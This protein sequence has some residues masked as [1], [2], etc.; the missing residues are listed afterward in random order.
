MGEPGARQVTV[1][2]LGARGEGVAEGPRGPI[3]IPHALPGELVTVQGEGERAAL[4]SVDRASPDRISPVCGHYTQCGGCA[5]QA[6]APESYAAWKRGLLVTALDHARV[7]AVIAPLV[8]SHGAGR[9]RATFHMRGEGA[10]VKAG[11]MRAR[12]HEIFDLDACPILAP[13]LAKAPQV[14]REVGRLLAHLG[15]PLDA[16]VTESE[17]G[18]DIDI[19]GAGRL[20]QSERAALL[21]FAEHEDLARISNHGEIVIE[22]R[23]PTLVMGRARVVPPPGAFLQATQ[24][25]EEALARLVV[26]ACKGAKRMAD[27]F[28]GVGT[29]ALR[30]AEGG[31]VHAVEGDAAAT[32]A[33][34]KAAR[35]AQLRVTC[36]TRDLFHRPLMPDELRR[37]DAVVFDPPRAGAEAQAQHLAQSEVPLVVAV[38][39]NPGTLA[40]D[41]AILVKGGYACEQVTPVDQF[42]YSAHLENVAVFRKAK[43]GGRKRGLLSR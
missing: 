17:N 32:L 30:L 19:R 20:G 42:L 39:C 33:L 28:A 27:L 21:R 8:V 2:R 18:L 6:F 25:G 11:F 15:K 12:S 26:D 14:A 23:P 31:E 37:F 10:R 9:R 22:R 7:K 5:V 13:A 24:A 43:S 36:E 34:D 29:F 41:A 1:E 35:F 16:L 3:Y 38:S 4:V 40:R